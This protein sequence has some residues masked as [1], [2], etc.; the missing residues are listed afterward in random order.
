MDQV[1]GLGRTRGDAG[2]ARDFL[3]VVLHQV[4]PQSLW[5]AVEPEIPGLDA[6]DVEPNQCRCVMGES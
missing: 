2:H 4:L 3:G 5:L 1:A 6:I